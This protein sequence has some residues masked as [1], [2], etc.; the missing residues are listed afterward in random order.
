MPAKPMRDKASSHVHEWLFRSLPLLG[1]VGGALKVMHPAQ[2]AAGIFCRESI[3]NLED[4]SITEALRH[5]A[6][7]FNAISV[8]NHR[9]SPLHR[10]PD[11]TSTMLDMLLTLGKYT[12]AIL[13]LRNLG[14]RMDYRPGSMVAFSGKMVRHGA[15]ECKGERSCHAFYMRTAVVER[16]N[17]EWPD[18]M[19]WN[20]YTKHD[21]DFVEALNRF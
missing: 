4:E 18:M 1:L 14:V 9:E 8:I 6:A 13:E 5:W 3:R 2:Y 19:K 7:P 10:D 15:S 12:G 21:E 11:T 20:T 17:V 16:A